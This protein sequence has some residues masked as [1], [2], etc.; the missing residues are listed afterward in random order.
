MSKL[1]IAIGGC[2]SIQ[3]DSRHCDR[4]ESIMTGKQAQ[5]ENRERR[6]S[7]LAVEW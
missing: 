3:Y 1:Q 4:V 6:A 7:Y 2:K 5:P